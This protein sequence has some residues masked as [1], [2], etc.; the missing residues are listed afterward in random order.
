MVAASAPLRALCCALALVTA[1]AACTAGEAPQP[2]AAT[3]DAPG[4]PNE[5]RMATGAGDVQVDPAALAAAQQWIAESSGLSEELQSELFLAAAQTGRGLTHLTFAQQHDG[6]PVRGAVFVVHVT[7]EGQVLG[8]SQSLTETLPADDATEE[9]TAEEAAEL[10][11]KAVPGTTTGQA[12]TRPTWLEVGTALRLGWEVLVT[13]SDPPANHAVVIDATTGEVLSVDPL[14]VESRTPPGV[15]PTAVT[16]PARTGARALAQAG[17]ACDAPAAPSACIFVVDPIYASGDP[18]ISPEEADAVLV[19]VPLENLSDPSAGILAGRYAAV[20]PAIAD[21]FAAPDGVWGAGGRDGGPA[22]EGGMTYYWID[23]TQR[24]VQSLG[25]SYHAGSPVGIV[26]LDPSVVDNAFYLFVEDRIHMG[27]GS[28]GVD[29]GEDAQGIIHEYG[30]ALLQAAVPNIVSPEGGAFHESF[31][32]LLS[33][34]VTLE[35]RNGDIGCLF[36]WAERGA[37]I[38]R[39]DTDLTYPDDLRFEVHADGEIFNGAVW[40]V[41]EAVLARDTGLAP[42]DCQQPDNPCGAVRD[43]VLA[44]LLGSLPFLT[45]QLDLAD[46]AS[47]FAAADLALFDGRNAAEIAGAF[48]AHGLDAGGTPAI[49]VEGLGP[50]RPAGPA[51]ALKV[52]HSYRGDLD[53]GI[54]VTDAA[55]GVLCEAIV[56][57]PDPSDAGDNVTGLFDLAGSGCEQHLPPGPEAVWTLTVADTLPEDE[58]VLLGYT[59]MDGTNRYPAPGLPVPIPDAD[60]AGIR[61]AVGGPAPGPASSDVLEEGA[62]ASGAVSVALDISHTYVGDLQVRVGVVDVASRTVR[63]AVDVRNPDPSDSTADLVGIVDAGS[64]TGFYPPSLQ[65]PWVLLVV[66][67]AALDVGS[68]QRFEVRGPDGQQFIAEGPVPIPD[69]DPSGAVLVVSG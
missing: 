26:P 69:A 57:T 45:P 16:P 62:T 28:D 68:I 20:P 59:V 17:S 64:C 27:A 18:G 23:Y 2:Q 36:H 66:D 19:G 67:T 58:G 29:E 21:T 5:V 37:C 41:F 1:L 4:T 49:Q 39:I 61:V 25:F 31:A 35:F 32:D 14:T 24:F 10:A 48:A 53:I 63:C 7:D 51:V 65:Q 15:R 34:L 54:D 55:G 33:V 52:Q 30:H 60:P 47:A 22:F 8:A 12:S 11:V 42:G 50:G 44:T 6:V 40:D 9:L 43:E 38:R 13:T 3:P 56:M 46:A